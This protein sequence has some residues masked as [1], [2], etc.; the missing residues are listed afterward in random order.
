MYT[1]R[2]AAGPMLC[3]SECANCWTARRSCHS[4]QPEGPRLDRLILGGCCARTSHRR[5][6]P[7]CP[8][9]VAPRPLLSWCRGPTREPGPVPANGAWL[10]FVQ[11]HGGGPTPRH[12]KSLGPDWAG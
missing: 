9:E 7:C 2:R 12:F 1:T 4:R 8:E 11:P 3:A 5:L 10:V 6:Q